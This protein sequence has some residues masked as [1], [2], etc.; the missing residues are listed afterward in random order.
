MSKEALSTFLKKV[1]EDESLQAK[2]IEFAASH[3]F[4]FTADELT[5]SDLDAVAGGASTIP[6]NTKV[7]M[8]GA[9]F[10][11]VCLTPSS[12]SAVPIPYPNT[13][14]TASSGGT[15]GESGTDTGGTTG[16]SSG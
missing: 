12:G 13:G 2:L 16:T 3:G 15:T 6:A 4:E 8:S 11:D 5:E 1:A 9:A 7:G 14:G 10:P